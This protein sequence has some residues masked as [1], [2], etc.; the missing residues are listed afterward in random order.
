MEAIN[1]ADLQTI[2]GK[3]EKLEEEKAELAD[4]QKDAYSEAQSMG[5]DVKTIK[6]VLKL[7]KKDSDALKEED[8]LMELYRGALGV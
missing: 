4:L 8:A 1:T 3:I 2:V 5:F 7:R 6:H